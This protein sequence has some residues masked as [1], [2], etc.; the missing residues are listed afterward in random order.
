[1]LVEKN[2]LSS[3]VHLVIKKHFRCCKI[4]YRFESKNYIEILFNC[5]F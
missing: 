4:K 2:P 1:M 3:P 5:Q